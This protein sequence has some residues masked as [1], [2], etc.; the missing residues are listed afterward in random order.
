MSGV[1]NAIWA[2]WSKEYIEP[3]RT[4]SV[5]GGVKIKSEEKNR[6]RW[7][8]GKNVELIRG[9]D[10]VVR[11]AKVQTEKGVMERTP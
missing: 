8:L 5:T 7:K 3:T 1:K 6:N 10:G 4:A 9:R 2:R 11:G